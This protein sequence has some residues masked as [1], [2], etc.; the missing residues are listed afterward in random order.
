[1][2]KV[3]LYQVEQLHHIYQN[4]TVTS[5]PTYTTL[6]HDWVPYRTASVRYQLLTVSE[7]KSLPSYLSPKILNTRWQINLQR[8]ATNR[9]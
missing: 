7:F 8:M 6:V 9:P 1:M 3:V 2:K 4:N 5:T